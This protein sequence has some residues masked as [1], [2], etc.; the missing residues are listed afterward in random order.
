MTCNC[1]ASICKNCFPCYPNA[2]TELASF[3]R[4]SFWHS[5]G[6]SGILS[7]CF[8]DGIADAYTERSVGLVF[9]A[10]PAN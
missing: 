6:L 1:K 7:D 3:V 10:W 2:A 4:V 9:D 8:R 5:V